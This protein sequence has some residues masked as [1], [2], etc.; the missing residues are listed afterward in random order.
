[1]DALSKQKELHQIS[2]M[3]LTPV[4]FPAMFFLAGYLYDLSTS[5]SLNHRLAGV[6]HMVKPIKTLV[7]SDLT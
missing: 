6:V 7:P 3:L 5:L 2:V 1:M 4:H